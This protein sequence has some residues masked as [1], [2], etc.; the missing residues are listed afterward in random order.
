MFTWSAD[1]DY[2]CVRA[3][4]R[5][6]LFSTALFRVEGQRRGHI[7][8]RARHFNAHISENKHAE[9]KSVQVVMVKETGV[10]RDRVL[11]RR[12]PFTEITTVLFGINR[13]SGRGFFFLFWLIIH[14]TIDNL[15]V[16][17]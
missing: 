3:F 14:L 8:R 9:R 11:N 13:G 5:C 7:E 15:A 2:V 1:V 10:G 6:L 4:V 17:L 12:K 16:P